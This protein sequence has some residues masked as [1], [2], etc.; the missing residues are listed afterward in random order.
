MR[1]AV[2]LDRDGVI[3]AAVV[4][5]RKPYSPK[6][7]AGIKILDGVIEAIKSLMAQNFI[8][9]IITN[10]PDITRKI[11]TES[12]L[13]S[14]HKIISKKTQIKHF[15][16]C[17]HDEKDLCECRKPKPGLITQAAKEL[18]LDLN[19]SFLVGDRWRDIAAA[20]ALNIESFFIDYSYAE[21]Q[22]SKPYTRVSSLLEVSKIL[23]ERIRDD[24]TY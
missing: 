1:R 24:F 22:P 9:V 2:F 14:M 6:N 4:L 20:Q 8:P 23:A 12:D 10:Q 19:S 21:K 13:I 11:I 15:Y 16:V 17:P 5:D 7:F 18:Q 3:N